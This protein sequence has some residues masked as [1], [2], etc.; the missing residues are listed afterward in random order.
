MK[1]VLFGAT[2]MVGAGALLA[3]LAD[4][5]VDSLLAIGRKPTGRAHPKLREHLS[6]GHGAECRGRCSSRVVPL[7]CGEPIAP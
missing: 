5:R 7:P 3:A 2:G 1:V 4:P 6:P